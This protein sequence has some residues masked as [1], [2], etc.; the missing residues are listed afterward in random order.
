M[1]EEGRQ[2]ERKQLLA[3]AGGPLI[4]SDFSREVN[5]EMGYATVAISCLKEVLCDGHSFVISLLFR[6]FYPELWLT[7]IPV[8]EIFWVRRVYIGGF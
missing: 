2:R 4:S 8:W 5:E 6:R 1:T 7:F 3:M